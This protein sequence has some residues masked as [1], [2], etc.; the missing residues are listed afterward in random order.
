MKRILLS[1]LAF[2][3]VAG[4]RV[5][6]QDAATQQQIDKL[7]GQLQDLQDAL[8]TRDKE[9]AD[10][11]K[12]VN[13]LSDKVNTPAVNNSASADDLKALATKV[14]EIDKKRQDDRDLILKRID[15][16]VKDSGGSTSGGHRS[17]STSSNKTPDAT[18]D[19]AGP[20]V[21]SK[22]Y[23]YVVKDGET[24]GAILKAYRAQGVK[25]TLSQF[26]AAN[27]K[28]NPDVLIPGQKIFIPDANAK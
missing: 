6:A 16:A 24:L 17:S 1:V 20:A 25:V 15:Q 19:N 26:K 10:L 13:E 22:G 14:Q 4:G 21:P 23:D 7:N 9:I 18:T 12:Q 2:S 11:T 8:A 28:I 3:L 5:H 27:P